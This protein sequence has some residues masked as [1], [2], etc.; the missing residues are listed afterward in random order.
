MLKDFESKKPDDKTALKAEIRELLRTADFAA[1][2][3][4]YCYAWANQH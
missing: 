3:Q 4:S 1:R 2:T